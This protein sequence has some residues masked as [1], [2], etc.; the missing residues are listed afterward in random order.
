MNK[1]SVVVVGGGFAGCGAALAAAK[2]GANVVLLER[3]DLLLAGG[4]GAGRMNY[5]GKLVITEETKALGAGEIFAALESIIL[6][7]GSIGEEHHGYVYNASIVEPTIRQLILK[8]K[9]I[10]VRFQSRA[11]QVKAQ[12]NHLTGVVLDGGEVV[13]GDTFIDCTGTTGGMS[14]C[15]KYGKGCVLCSW[16]RCPTYGDRVSVAAKAGAKEFHKRASDGSKGA[17]VA[18]ILLLK[19]SMAPSLRQEL[20]GK[21][22]LVIPLPHD[23]VDYSKRQNIS[24]MGPMRQMESLNLV[25]IGTGAKCVRIGYLA[26]EQLRSIPGLENVMVQDPLSGGTFNAIKSVSMLQCDAALLVAGFD[27]LLCGGEKTGPGGGVAECIALG[28]VAGHNAVRIACR[29]KPLVLPETLCLGDFIKYTGEMVLTPGGLD[30]NYHAGHGHYFDRMKQLDLYTT[31][32]DRIHRKVKDA[33]L[34]KTFSEKIV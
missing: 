31:D 16:Y 6:H 1:K 7:R 9:N 10:A 26:L 22:S 18:A 2:A 33:G 29:M 11:A 23:L 13:E 20:E 4:M 14:V 8:E 27:N 34:D 24:S 3:T 5:N 15:K 19:D 32:I 12:G 21:G 30:F 25:D 28:I 17:I